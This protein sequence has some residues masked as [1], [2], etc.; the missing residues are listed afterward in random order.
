[1]IVFLPSKMVQNDRNDL[2]MD[3]PRWL[4]GHQRRRAEA[5]GAPQ[6]PRGGED[7]TGLRRLTEEIDPFFFLRPDMIYII[8]I[9]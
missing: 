9:N 3:R 2:P 8:Y 4:L 6:H 5:D 1:M 7:V